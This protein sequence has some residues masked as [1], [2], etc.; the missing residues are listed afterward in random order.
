MSLVIGSIYG[1]LGS[2]HSIFK[3]SYQKTPVEK[4]TFAE[5]KRRICKVDR[6][7]EIYKRNYESED[8]SW[9]FCNSFRGYET[10]EWLDDENFKKRLKIYKNNKPLMIQR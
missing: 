5:I 6:L 8:D 4:L 7:N 2:G 9:E 3:A 1:M 10:N